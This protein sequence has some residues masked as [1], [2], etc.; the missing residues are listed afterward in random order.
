MELS[1][2]LELADKRIAQRYAGL[3]LIRQGQI[4]CA[5]A[6][7]MTGEIGGFPMLK[8]TRISVFVKDRYITDKYMLRVDTDTA[9][10]I[11]EDPSGLILG[12]PLLDHR[13]LYAQCGHDPMFMEADEDLI[14]LQSL[15]HAS[16]AVN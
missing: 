11:V 3:S 6:Y 7:L 16:T 14:P 2:A 12:P 1:T 9:W 13:E 4:K 10:S 8:S 5:F 15:L